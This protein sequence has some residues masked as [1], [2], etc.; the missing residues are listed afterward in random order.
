MKGKK[1]KKDSSENKESQKK[2]PTSLKRKKCSSSEHDYDSKIKHEQHD[3]TYKISSPE[4]NTMKKGKR[5]KLNAQSE[6]KEAEN[7]LFPL[8]NRDGE[9]PSNGEGPSMRKRENGKVNQGQKANRE[10]QSVSK[11]E[12]EKGNPKE[13]AKMK[14][15]SRRKKKDR[16]IDSDSSLRFLFNEKDMAIDEEKA[17]GTDKKM[18]GRPGNRVT[19]EEGKAEKHKEVQQAPAQQKEKLLMKEITKC[20]GTVKVK[21]ANNQK[22]QGDLVTLTNKL[23]TNV[24][25]SDSL[26]MVQLSS[27]EDADNNLLSPCISQAGMS[28]K[29]EC[30]KG[31]RKEMIPQVDEHCKQGRWKFPLEVIDNLIFKNKTHDYDKWVP[32]CCILLVIGL[33]LEQKEEHLLHSLIDIY[34]RNRNSDPIVDVMDLMES[35]YI[36]QALY[37]YSAV[38]DHPNKYELFAYRLGIIKFA[39]LFGAKHN[40][41]IN[42][43]DH[44]HLQ[45]NLSELCRTNPCTVGSIA[46][47]YFRNEHFA[48]KFWLAFKSSANYMYEKYVRI[49]PDKNELKVYIEASI[50]FV[51]PGALFVNINYA[52]LNVVLNSLQ[53]KAPTVFENINNLK[54]KFPNKTIW[55]LIDADVS[56]DDEPDESDELDEVDEVDA[57]APAQPALGETSL[58]GN[59]NVRRTFIAHSS[60]GMVSAAKGE[61]SQDAPSGMGEQKDENVVNDVLEDKHVDEREDEREDEHADERE[62]EHADAREDESEDDGDDDDSP[63]LRWAKA[64]RFNAFHYDIPF[65][66]NYLLEREDLES[67]R[68]NR[69]HCT[70]NFLILVYNT[71]INKYL[72]ENGLCL[73]ACPYLDREAGQKVANFLTKFYLLDWTF[74]EADDACYF[75]LFKSVVNVFAV[76]K[77]AFRGVFDYVVCTLFLKL[78]FGLVPAVYIRLNSTTLDNMGDGLSMTLATMLDEGP[79]VKQKKDPREL[80]AAVQTG[81]NEDHAHTDN[82]ILTPA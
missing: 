55:D 12:R 68:Q 18:V 4:V 63:S 7:V 33:P 62:D 70:P 52:Q 76:S 36:H 51:M 30:V 53:Q 67:P 72:L 48:K 58:E 16:I 43:I 78:P 10:K 11:G 5:K 59:D 39:L 71:H 79:E 1:Q 49:I 22:G 81:K 41:S 45:C 74:S 42:L 17:K 6:K 37:I 15:E 69:F 31:G 24:R 8:D 54:C 44:T 65:D 35:D 75:Y 34:Y 28:M 19:K 26:A 25:V 50:Y 80:I 47:L 32:G 13:D 3:K 14:S 29:E 2:D 64:H 61:S 56:F 38:E 23:N 46:S 82:S 73:L 40:A 66:G 57:E 9:Y 21:N 27:P 60:D 20:Y 77:K